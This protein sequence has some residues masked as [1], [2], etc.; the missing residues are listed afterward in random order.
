MNKILSISPWPSVWSQGGGGGS[1]SET[2]AIQAMTQAGFHVT[3]VSPFSNGLPLLEESENVRFVR[4]KHNPFESLRFVL[5]TGFA[6]LYRLPAISLWTELVSCWVTKSG[7]KFDLVVGHSSETIFALRRVARRLRV[8]AVT[9]LY[10]VSATH[11][12]LSRGIRKELY[13]DLLS[14]LRNPPDHLVITDD[15]TCGDVICSLFRIPKSKYDFLVNGYEPSILDMK[16]SG[17]TAPY[18]LTA[19]RLVDWKRMDKVVSIAAIVCQN[20][21]ELQFVI[22]GDGP[23][24][25]S[26]RK[27]AD[28]L[29]V[30]SNVN[31]AGSVPRTRMYEYLYDA[32]IVLSTQDLSNITNTV[33][34]ALVMG[35]PVVA[36]DTGCSAMFLRHENTS[37][38]FPSHDIQ[39]A[40][41][42]IETLMKDDEFRNRLGSN[43]RLFSKEFFKPWPER[44]KEEASIYKRF[45]TT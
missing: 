45:K 23:E 39:G 44:V 27:L 24:R 19:G 21:P 33:I 28:K 26:L 25:D 1:P 37:L 18:V 16:P 12:R 3:H 38:L 30:S 20:L 42:G 34:E 35:K 22:L 14:L 13:F 15:G 5:N 31:F 36:F 17:R 4:I 43:A 40:A 6:F 2:Y 7:E 11:E 41:R 29:G 32:S 9:R 8:P 10:G